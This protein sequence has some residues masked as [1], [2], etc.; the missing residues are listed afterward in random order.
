MTTAPPF[1]W[2]WRGAENRRLAKIVLCWV[3]ALNVWAVFAYDVL[4]IS[5]RSPWGSEIGR[6]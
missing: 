3:F 5:R 4:P 2:P 6:A 1:P